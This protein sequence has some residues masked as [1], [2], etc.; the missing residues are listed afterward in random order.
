MF[1]TRTGFPVEHDGFCGF[2]REVPGFLIDALDVGVFSVKQ[3]GD[4]ITGAFPGSSHL[5][6]KRFMHAFYDDVDALI[7]AE[8][9]ENPVLQSM[10]SG[11]QRAALTN[12]DHGNGGVAAGEP[13]LVLKVELGFDFEDQGRC[14]TGFCELLRRANELY[15]A[16][17]HLEFA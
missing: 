14:A 15:A 10:N 9:V 7:R 2:A 1:F 16:R 17:F 4:G 8:I 11:F 6:V 3:A 5:P 12:H 13:F